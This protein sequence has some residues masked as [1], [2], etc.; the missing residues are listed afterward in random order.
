M[1][2]KVKVVTREGKVIS[3]EHWQRTYGL[4]V[5]SVRIGHFFY[6]TETRF[7]KDLQLYGI[8]VVNEL[9]I[10]FLDALRKASQHPITLNSFNRSRSHQAE[11]RDR[12]FRAAKDSP[13]VVDVIG[14]EIFGGLA[15]DIDTLSEQETRAMAK[16]CREVSSII[17]IKIRI[18]YEQYLSIGDTFVHI[19]VCPEFYAPGKPWHTRPHPEVWEKEITW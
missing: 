9:L 2:D 4:P 8:L 12:G 7:Q 11:L 10:R 5:G 6:L 15:A 17:N 18:G 13:H 14:D 3:L 16:R 19:D 1:N